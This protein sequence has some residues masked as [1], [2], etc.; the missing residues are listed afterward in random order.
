M[1]RTVRPMPSTFASGTLRQYA[2]LLGGA[3]LLS[4][5]ISLS[6]NAGLGVG[7]WQVFETGLIATTGASFAVVA[8]IESVVVLL[9]A[10]RWLGQ[11]PGPA[12]VLFAALIGPLVSWL[13]TVVPV[14]QDT[15]SAASLLAVGI[16]LIGVGVGLYVGA[17][18]GASAQD[19]LFVGV[20]TRFSWRPR[21]ARLLTDVL[22]VGGG[23][24]LGGQV[25]V[26]TVVITLGL[27][28]VIEPGM[29]AGAALAAQPELPRSLT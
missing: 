6:I 17:G 5:G 8:V 23:W 21:T 4:V 25:G 26:G 3:A 14:A 18:L 22:L 20:F 16:V 29:R 28:L 15:A 27:P 11:L 19:S 9:V 24:A 10:W 13:L 7:S 1:R 12:T 2:V